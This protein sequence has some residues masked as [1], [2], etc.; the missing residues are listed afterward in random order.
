MAILVTWLVDQKKGQESQIASGQTHEVG[1]PS[2]QEVTPQVMYGTSRGSND[3]SAKGSN[4]RKSGPDTGDK[5]LT[6]GTDSQHLI[7]KS[8]H[9]ILQSRMDLEKM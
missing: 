7:L 2:I 8:N 3:G 9:L 6:G 1:Y 4:V 5:H